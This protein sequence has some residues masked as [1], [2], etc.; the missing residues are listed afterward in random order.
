[1]RPLVPTLLS[2]VS[3]APAASDV[4]ASEPPMTPLTKPALPAL[5]L[6]APEHLET[7]TFALG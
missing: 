7:A 2:L 4:E 1:M 5:D 3:C 6:R